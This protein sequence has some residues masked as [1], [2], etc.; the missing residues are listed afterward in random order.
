ME[1]IKGSKHTQMTTLFSRSG[2]MSYFNETS[3]HTKQSV[4]KKETKKTEK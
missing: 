1:H 3:L 4:N 2:H